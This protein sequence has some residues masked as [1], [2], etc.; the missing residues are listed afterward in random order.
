[1]CALRWPRPQ[2][3]TSKG[4][5]LPGFGVSLILSNLFAALDGGGGRHRAPPS[6]PELGASY[7]VGA[8]LGLG[9]LVH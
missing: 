3:L 8:G 6:M 7:C 1:M 2:L 4:F 5:F 9:L